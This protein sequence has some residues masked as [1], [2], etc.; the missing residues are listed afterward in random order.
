MALR[1]LGAEYLLRSV[2]G[3]AWPI[4]HYRYVPYCVAITAR[5]SCHCQ[6][7]ASV[8]SSQ[9]VNPFG[10]RTWRLLR[11]TFFAIKSRRGVAKPF[12]LWSAVAQQ[13]CIKSCKSGSWHYVH[14][15]VFLCR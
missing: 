3:P 9:P 14:S 4:L 7:K 8:W 2:Q 1:A 5:N 10:W 6:G 15:S 12:V 11:H 13:R